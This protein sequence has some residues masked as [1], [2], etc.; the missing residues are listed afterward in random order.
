MHSGLGASATNSRRSL[1]AFPTFLW[2]TRATLQRDQTENPDKAES[3]VRRWVSNIGLLLTAFVFLHLLSAGRVE[4]SLRNE[5]RDCCGVG[6]SG[7]PL[8]QPRLREVSC[9][10]TSHLASHVCGCAAFAM[11][12]TLGLGF[13]SNGSPS[14]VR[15][16]NEDARRVK[17]LRDLTVQVQNE[18]LNGLTG[19]PANLADVGLAETDPFTGRAYEYQRLDDA[20]YQVCAEFGSSVEAALLGRPDS[21]R[22]RQDD[23][24]SISASLVKYPTRLTIFSSD[25]PTVTQTIRWSTIGRHEKSLQARASSLASLSRW[26]RSLRRRSSRLLPAGQK[27]G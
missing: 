22:I 20:R 15:V 23:S 24:A 6:R 8:L 16:L 3:A 12:L 10:P 26:R 11:I 14:T 5:V 17:D 4:D 7:I 13:W 2:A 18:R 1:F 25:N 27:P 19:P 21:G 9:A